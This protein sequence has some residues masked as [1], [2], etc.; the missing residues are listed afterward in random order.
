MALVQQKYLCYLGACL[1]ATPGRI[2]QLAV[3]TRVGVSY[4]YAH[5]TSSQLLTQ[6]ADSIGGYGFAL[7]LEL[8]H[9]GRLGLAGALPRE[10][11]QL[12]Q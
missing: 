6:S 7:P 10:L 4:F 2:T 5:C 3:V 8:H 11:F 1:S 12:G 9:L